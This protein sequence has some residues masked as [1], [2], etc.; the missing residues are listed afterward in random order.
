MADPAWG[1]TFEEFRQ[2]RFAHAEN[3]IVE[4]LPYLQS[5]AWL[6]EHCTEFGTRRAYSTSALISGCKGKVVS[7]DIDRR[8][9]V[10]FLRN[11]PLP[12]KWEFRQCSTIDPNISIE[13][14]DLL[15]IDT[16]HTYEQV[17]TELLL[18]SYKV[19]RYIVFHDTAT[20]RNEPG[21]ENDIGIL[22][23]VID[24]IIDHPEWK[25]IVNRK[26]CNGLLVLERAG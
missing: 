17:K 24:F 2:G 6:C 20:P 26:N 5:L 10:D 18:H 1:S 13:Y 16:L 9:E 22:N 23:A 4:H 11:I 12:C 7:Y 14:T 15:F 19:G 8:E 3:D 21:H 25:P